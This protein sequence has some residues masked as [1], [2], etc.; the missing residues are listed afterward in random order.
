[1]L[2]NH[3]FAGLEVLRFADRLAAFKLGQPRAMPVTSEDFGVGRDEEGIQ[4]KAAA[5]RADDKLHRFR[6]MRSRLL[7][8]QFAEAFA[9][10]GV[11]AEKENRRTGRLTL[12]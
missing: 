4:E 2:M 6:R 9:F 11:V 7:L 5:Q 1:M 3:V 12:G 8:K 10:A